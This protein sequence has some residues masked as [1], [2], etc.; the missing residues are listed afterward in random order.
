MPGRDPARSLAAVILAAGQGKRLRSKLPKVLHPVC[1]RPSL[2]HVLRA[3]GAARPDR[4]AIVVGVGRERV[5]EA[6]RSWGLSPEPVFVEQPEPLGTGHAVLVAEA[7]VGPADDVLV[8]AGDD[9][10]IG[11]EHVRALLRVHRRTRAAASVIVTEVEDPSG[12]G[13]VRRDGYRLIGI[14][15]ERDATPEERRIRE[16]STCAYAFRREDLYAAL[17]LV[18]RENVQGEYYL[19]DVLGILLAKG[20][21]VSAVPAD[22][23]GWAGVNSRASAAEAAR[24]LR[25]RIN[26][27]HLA[28]G[29]TLVDPERTYIDAEV[30][31]GRDTVVHPMT[32]LEGTTRIGR[33]CVI[34]PAARIRDSVVGDGA[35][36]SFSVVSGARLGRRV[37]VGPY[38]HVRP[39]TV[40]LEGAKIGSFVE[41]KNARIGRGAKVPHLA[42]VGD[43]TVGARA[44]LG[45]GTVT[46]NYDGYAKHRTVIGEDARVG[47]D[48]MLVAPVRVGRGAV[49]GAGSVITRDVPAGALAVERTEQRIVRGYR[50]R[51]DAE[52][53]RR[54]SRGS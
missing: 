28:R 8:L 30:R 49:T 29:V 48:T 42:Y 10:L 7:A 38:S 21:R 32:F 39:G 14:V 41:V 2:W 54:T 15:E 26:A 18:G 35:E 50:A 52:H 13:R 45:A 36:V 27:G 37:T 4:I 5:E 11:P 47:S 9:P 51:K 46:V 40:A 12:Y 17:P 53:A 44:N 33:D 23:G 6:V 34:G 19:P 22:F 1:G 25:R 31:I 24:L 20:E 16:I 43:A 3:A